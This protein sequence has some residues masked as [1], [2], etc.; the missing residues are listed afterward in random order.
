[1]RCSLSLF[2]L[3][4]LDIGLMMYLLKSLKN[5]NINKTSF[6]VLSMDATFYHATTPI[7]ILSNLLIVLY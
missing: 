7:I 1:M 6:D 4:N 5:R 3:I 2:L